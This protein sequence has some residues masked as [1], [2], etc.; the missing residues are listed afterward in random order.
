MKIYVACILT[1]LNIILN[2]L[3]CEC[4]HDIVGYKHTYNLMTSRP[5]L[6]SI[7]SCFG[8]VSHLLEK[9][10]QVGHQ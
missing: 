3:R 4:L 8:I 1:D 7:S 6:T 9:S 5:K 2:K 10:L